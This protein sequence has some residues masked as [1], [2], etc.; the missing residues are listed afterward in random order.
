[1]GQRQLC[2]KVSSQCGG[3]SFHSRDLGEGGGDV[4]LQQGEDIATP[5]TQT[6]RLIKLIGKTG[7]RMVPPHDGNLWWVW[8]DGVGW[9]TP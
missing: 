4:Q 2:W 3:K 7:K 8:W 9:G 1:M 5:T 6:T